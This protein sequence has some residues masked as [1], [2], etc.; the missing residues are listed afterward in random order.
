MGKELRKEKQ[1]VL[2]LKVGKTP[3]HGLFST[4]NCNTSIGNKGAKGSNCM[5]NDTRLSK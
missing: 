2:P 3:R 1:N 5:M 4:K